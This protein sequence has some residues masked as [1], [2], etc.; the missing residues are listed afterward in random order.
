MAAAHS[1]YE[2]IVVDDEV[3]GGLMAAAHSFYER[4]VVVVDSTMVPSD[5]L[6]ICLKDRV[7]GP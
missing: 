6:A 3:L 7:A 2:R 1:F 4:I 5:S